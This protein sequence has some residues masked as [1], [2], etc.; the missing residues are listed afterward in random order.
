VLH[1]L[2][3]SQVLQPGA[4]IAVQVGGEPSTVQLQGVALAAH[5]LSAGLL[6]WLR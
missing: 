6:Y 3:S 4:S 5:I 2:L 1:V